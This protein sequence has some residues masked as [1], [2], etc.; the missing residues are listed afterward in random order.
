MMLVIIF[1]QFF[2]FILVLFE[3]MRFEI[4]NYLVIKLNLL[5]LAAKVQF[6]L[7]GHSAGKSPVRF[8]VYRHKVRH[9]SQ[10]KL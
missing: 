8:L 5:K 3:I 6:I 7:K 1:K 9:P 10:G 2:Y 4:T